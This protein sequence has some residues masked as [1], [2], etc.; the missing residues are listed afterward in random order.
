MHPLFRS[1][2][3]MLWMTTHARIHATGK[4]KWYLNSWVHASKNVVCH[5]FSW[6][7]LTAEKKLFSVERRIKILLQLVITNFGD[8]SLYFEVARNVYLKFI[9]YGT[10][11]EK[12]RSIKLFLFFMTFGDCKQSAKWEIFLPK[13]SY[14]EKSRNRVHFPF[15]LNSRK[16]CPF[17]V[18]SGLSSCSTNKNSC[19]FSARTRSLI[20]YLGF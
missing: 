2:K 9:S 6:G 4:L 10:A 8:M 3:F 14:V 15:L 16:I 5:N 20:V 17:L 13:S 19:R 12:C 11:L 7:K 18:L 1:A